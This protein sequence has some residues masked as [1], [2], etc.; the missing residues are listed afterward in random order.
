M[1]IVLLEKVFYNN[2]MKIIPYIKL[3]RV[4]HYIKNLFVFVPLIFSMSFLNLN[5]VGKAVIAFIQ[6]CLASSIIYIA[7]DICDVEKDRAHPKKKNRPIASGEISIKKANYLEVFLIALEI[8]LMLLSKNIYVSITILSYLLMNFLYSFYLKKIPILDVMIIAIGFLLR[9]YAGAFA[10]NVEVSH[11]LLLTAFSLSLFL[12]FGK[13]Y[14]EKNKTN[15]NGREVLEG[16][17]INSLKTF[18]IISL[19]LTLVFYSL[20]CAAGDNILGKNGILTVPIVIFAFFRY[21]LI[22]GNEEIDGDPTDVILN[23]LPIKVSI[24]AYAI[25]SIILVF[26]VK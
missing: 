12:G 3:L 24:L 23:D 18:M 19:S 11:W 21:Y 9:I 4:K 26:G 17:D 5:L 10:I 20:Y 22:L 7:N 15:S 13:R 2:N 1:A 8:L 16:Y 25:V 14:G 6:F